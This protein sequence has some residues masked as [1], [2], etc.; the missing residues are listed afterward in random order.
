MPNR[1]RAGLDT[2]ILED[3]EIHKVLRVNVP[4]DLP[5]GAV[6][7]KEQQ[8]APRRGLD[9]AHQQEIERRAMPEQQQELGTLFRAGKERRE[10]GRSEREMEE[11]D[12]KEMEMRLREAREMERDKAAALR[13]RAVEEEVLFR[14]RQ[15]RVL[16]E[17]IER[18]RELKIAEEARAVRERE[19][20]RVMR[21]AEREAER[22][23]EAMKKA[24]ELE[25]AAIARSMQESIITESARKL[26]DQDEREKRR[27]EAIAE[28]ERQEVK[29]K[30]HEKLRMRADAAKEWEWPG[31]GIKTSGLDEGLGL[32]DSGVPLMRSRV[33]DVRALVEGESGRGRYPRTTDIHRTTYAAENNGHFGPGPEPT[34]YRYTSPYRAKTSPRGGR[35][36]AESG[37]REPHHWDRALDRHRVHETELWGDRAAANTTRRWRETTTERWETIIHQDEGR[38]AYHSYKEVSKSTRRF[39]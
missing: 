33:D 27:A 9:R 30:A 17:Q 28:R 31:A 32:Y 2:W 5:A 16:R 13:Q 10:R 11:S 38:D 39:L 14:L 37:T 35:N 34:W 24:M 8:P 6:N 25:E 1:N 22:E 19:R 15:E 26:V 3:I 29:M 20:V 36:S 21:D 12:M 23:R 4:D 7:G 18:E